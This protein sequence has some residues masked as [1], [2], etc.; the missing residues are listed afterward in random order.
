MPWGWHLTGQQ[1][2]PELVLL[3]SW[4]CHP[5]SVPIRAARARH[6]P[7]QVP[8]SARGCA[9]GCHGAPLI[10]TWLIVPSAADVPGTQTPA[11]SANPVALAA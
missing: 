2:Q 8:T 6:M 4:Q 7:S 9:Q 1:Q 10:G 3:P 5:G 11:I